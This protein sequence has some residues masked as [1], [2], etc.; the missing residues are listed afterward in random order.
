MEEFR[1]AGEIQKVF[2]PKEMAAPA[3]FDIHGDSRP[4]VSAGGDYFDYVTLPDGGDRDRHR[5]RERPWARPRPP[6]GLDPRLSA[7]FASKYSDVG[8]IL[9][10]LNQV[11]LAD[12]GDERFVT[13]TLA[14]LDP[15]T[16]SLVYANAGHTTGYVLDRSGEVKALL[17]SSGL[18]LGLA[19]DEEYPSIRLVLEPGDLVLLLTDGVEEAGAVLDRPFGTGRILETVRSHRGEPARSIVAA[20]HRTVLEFTRSEVQS[21]D[22]TAIVIKVEI[23]GETT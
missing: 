22:M 10:R 7:P 16:R 1:I 8:T 5:R 20:L 14:R 18:P 6:D 4:A 19:P 12:V 2:Y 13:L 23:E 17:E 15:A 21:D 11:L 9:T 3:G